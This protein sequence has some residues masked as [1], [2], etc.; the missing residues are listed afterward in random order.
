MKVVVEQQK[1]TVPESALMAPDPSTVRTNLSPFPLSL[2]W[3]S[4]LCLA[5]TGPAAATAVS[6]ATITARAAITVSLALVAPPR[7]GREAQNSVA[8]GSEGSL[9]VR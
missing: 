7:V 9:R 2:T 3:I 8:V 4:T 6:V 5:P 1:L